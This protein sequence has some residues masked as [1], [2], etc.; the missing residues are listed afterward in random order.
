MKLRAQ[1]DA[2]A[3]L[4]DEGA[5]TSAVRMLRSS[6]DP[7]LEPDDRLPLYCMW[8]RALCDNSDFAKAQTLAERAVEEFPREPDVLIALGNVLD[9]SGELE[10]ARQV[11]VKVLDLE[12]SGLAHYNVGTVLERLGDEQAAEDHYRAALRA[13]E[14]PTTDFEAVTALGALLRRS[15]RVHDAVDVYDAYLVDDPLNVDVLVEQAICLSDTEALGEAI[16]RFELVLSLD[17]EHAGAWYNLSVAQYR[18]GAVADA[19]RSMKQAK[20]LDANSPLTLAVLGA[21]ALTHDKVKGAPDL[22][23]ALRYLY[24]A[25]EKLRAMDEGNLSPDYAGL[26]CEEVFEALWQSG[27]RDEGREVARLAGQRDW[28]TEHM[29]NTLNEADHGRSSELEAFVVTARAEADDE[30]AEHW[31][32]DARG[33]RTGLTVLATNEDEARRYSLEYLR[34]LDPQPGVRFH[35]EAVKATDPALLLVADKLPRARGV[36]QVP[37]GRAYFRQ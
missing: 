25:V 35:I 33:Y 19:I 17:R 13:E 5:A 31:P 14:E 6:W 24:I 37:T 28:I 29:L 21:W 15:G 36:V 27:R 3:T 10:R 12:A 1:L 32:Q 30:R 34:A 9:L 18:L 7:E 22:D 20:R 8:I 11:F 4:L 16:D 2:A 23:E 26:V